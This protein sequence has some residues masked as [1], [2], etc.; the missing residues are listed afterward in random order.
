MTGITPRCGQVRQPT[1]LGT[2]NISLPGFNILQHSTFFVTA[3]TVY[4]VSEYNHEARSAK[5]LLTNLK[6]VTLKASTRT[7]VQHETQS[8]NQKLSLLEGPSGV[9]PYVLTLRLYKWSL[10]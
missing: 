7:Q 4:H 10:I 3:G 1:W 8:D 6:F 5:S 9:N 2:S